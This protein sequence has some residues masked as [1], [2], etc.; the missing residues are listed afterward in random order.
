VKATSPFFAR[1]QQDVV[2]IV[3]SIPK[4]SLLTFQSIGAHLDVVP[5]H[6]AYILAMRDDGLLA[7]IPWHRVVPADGVLTKPKMH[8]GS[9]QVE[10]LR[11]EGVTIN[12]DGVITD[13]ENGIK[14]QVRPADA[15]TSSSPRARKR[16]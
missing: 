15:P 4:G 7:N 13:L 16:K 14:K 9:T 2:S 12:N 6:V 8:Q 5:R 3:K 1:I 11:S 10:R